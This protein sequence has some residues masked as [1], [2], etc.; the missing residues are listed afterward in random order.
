MTYL[1]VTA[2]VIS[3]RTDTYSIRVASSE[4]FTVTSDHTVYG[5][6][7]GGVSGGG[8]GKAAAGG[9]AAAAVEEVF[10]CE[11]DCGFDGGKE[12]VEEHEKTCGGSA[13]T[14]KKKKRSRKTKGKTSAIQKKKK[15]GKKK[16]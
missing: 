4:R 13:E 7:V 2:R 14:L 11:Y 1:T 6:D 9:G 10:E 3:G 15:K 12:S 5:D 8:G 16:K